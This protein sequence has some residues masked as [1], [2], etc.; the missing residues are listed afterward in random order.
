MCSTADMKKKRKRGK[1][2]GEHTE[3][4]DEIEIERISRLMSKELG[5]AL[6]MSVVRGVIDLHEQKAK[7]RGPDE[8][9]RSKREGRQQPRFPADDCKRRN[10]AE[11]GRQHADKRDGKR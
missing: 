4:V 1:Q 10:F 3:N 5:G 7:W 8:M 11:E 6:S 2:E 9:R